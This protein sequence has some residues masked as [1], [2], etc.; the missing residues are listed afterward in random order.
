MTSINDTPGGVSV[1]FVPSSSLDAVLGRMRRHYS[2]AQS[3][4]FSE[5]AAAC[6]LYLRGLRLARSTDGRAIDITVTST[7]MSQESRKRV[8]EEAVFANQAHGRT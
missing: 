8:R 4:G 5:E 1:E 7:E 3:R 6:P 2:F